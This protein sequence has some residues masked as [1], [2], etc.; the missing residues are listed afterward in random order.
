MLRGLVLTTVLLSATW[1]IAAPTVYCDHGQS[2]SRMLSQMNKSVPTTILVQGTCT[3]S[4][5]ISGFDGLTLKALPGATLRL[6]ATEPTN[7]VLTI[8]ASRS[9][10]VDG[11]TIHSGDSGGSAV[12]VRGNSLDVRLRNLTIDGS[13]E[14]VVYEASQASLAKINIGMSSGYAAVSVYDVSDVHLEDAVLDNRTRDGF[15]HSGVFVYAGHVT[16]HGTVIRNMQQS[17][18]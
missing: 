4:I 13:W 17:I 10:T 14:I 3:E 15:F 1:V 18:R 8:Q 11:F 2:L 5:Q 12:G 9:V 6:P 16:M 7:V